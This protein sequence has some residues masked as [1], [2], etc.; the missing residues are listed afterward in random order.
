[1]AHYAAILCSELDPEPFSVPNIDLVEQGYL[2][3]DETLPVLTLPQGVNDHRN[4]FSMACEFIRGHTVETSTLTVLVDEI[5]ISNLSVLSSSKP[6]ALIAMLVLAFPEIRWVFMEVI[7]TAAANVEEGVLDHSSW[8]RKNYGPTT[9]CLKHGTP[10]FDGYGLRDFIRQRASG[11]LD[12]ARE[13]EDNRDHLL[14]PGR[15]NTAVV[16]DD[17]RDFRYYMSLMAFTRGFRVYS[18]N[19]WAEAEYLLGEKINGKGVLVDSDNF[20][21][22]I[23]DMFLDFPDQATRGVSNLAT[24]SVALPALGAKSP[25]CRRFITIGHHNSSSKS[26]RG[27]QDNYLRQRREYESRSRVGVK[28]KRSEQV[29]YKP[30]P[31]HYELW[32]DLGLDRVFT[33][34]VHHKQ[35]RG[36]VLNFEWP[37]IWPKQ[38]DNEGGGRGSQ[39]PSHSSPGRMQQVAQKLIDDAMPNRHTAGTLR[40]AAIGAVKATEALELLAGKTPTLSLE[41]LGLKHAFEL[42]AT[43]HFVGV[44][45]HLNMSSRLKE[46]R[47]NLVMLAHWIN[48]KRRHEFKLHGEAQILTKMVDVLSRYGMYE[49]AEMCRTRLGSVHRRIEIINDLKNFSIHRVPLWP[50]KLYTNWVLKSV[51]NFTV[52]LCVGIIL[53]V[54]GFIILDKSPA[55]ALQNTVEAMLPTPA[56]KDGDGL[57]IKLLTYGGAMFGMINFGFLI[58]IL[59]SKVTRK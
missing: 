7:E 10:L 18:V 58:A 59:Y 17:E 30:A 23:E 51:A 47:Q 26:E 35:Q 3:S 38:D 19:T 14:I 8:L 4:A 44:E 39:R 32:G 9:L 33:K 20:L 22:S 43:C 53:F 49:E 13:E 54:L 56:A 31:G 50:A 36:I 5:D 6:S 40:Q 16:I 2:A 57:A 11:A 41:A 52:A 21:L 45:Y 28:P 27:Q 34:R 48:K 55:D 1:M 42:L 15:N 12:G 25:A 46:I 29:I 24:R 37:I